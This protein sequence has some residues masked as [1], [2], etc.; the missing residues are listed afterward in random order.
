LKQKEQIC[1]C[2]K[3]REKKQKEPIKELKMSEK[4][5][6]NKDIDKNEFIKSLCLNFKEQFKTREK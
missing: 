3:T 6:F 5:G 1:E 2:L 4:S